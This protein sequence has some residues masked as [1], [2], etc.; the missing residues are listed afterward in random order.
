MASISRQF[1]RDYVVFNSLPYFTYCN[2]D[3]LENSFKFLRESD[4]YGVWASFFYL[5]SNNSDFC[6]GVPLFRR[7]AG[8]GDCTNT[9]MDYY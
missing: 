8:M 7:L 1:R 2:G 6:R 9:N 4:T 5:V 3:L